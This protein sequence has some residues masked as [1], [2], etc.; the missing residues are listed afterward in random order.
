MLQFMV[1]VFRICTSEFDVFEQCVQRLPA[2]YFKIIKYTFKEILNFSPSKH[3][4]QNFASLYTF[5]FSDL[6]YF[7]NACYGQIMA[8]T[9]SL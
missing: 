2:L 3:W 8:A 4:I 6:Q 9:S 1:P 5:K 7:E